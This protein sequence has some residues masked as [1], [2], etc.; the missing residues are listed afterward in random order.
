MLDGKIQ[1]RDCLC[2][3]T[4]G[5]IDNQES[6]LA[7]CNRTRNLIREVHVTRSI[8]QIKSICFT[9]IDIIH[10]DRMALDGNTLL[11]LKVHGIKDLVLHIT[12]IKSIGNLEHSVC[13]STLAM[14][15]MRNDAKVSCLLHFSFHE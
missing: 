13:Q 5:C 12:G 11:L 14:V 8:N 3:N 10:L 4:L 1:V 2:L 6:S 9:F 7:R 15:N